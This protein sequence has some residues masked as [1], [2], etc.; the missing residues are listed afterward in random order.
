MSSTIIHMEE[1]LLIKIHIESQKG[2]R[3]RAHTRKIFLT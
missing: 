3:N 1:Y 2:D